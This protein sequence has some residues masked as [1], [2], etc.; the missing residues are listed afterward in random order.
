MGHVHLRVADLGDAVA[1]YRDLLGFGL[2]AELFGSA[3]FF[4]AGGYHHHVGANTWQSLGA[5]PPPPGAAALRR[6]TI[7]LPDGS[8]LDRLAERVARAGLA[9]EGHDGGVLVRDPSGTAVV[10]AA[11]G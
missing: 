3:A 9:P 6:V 11:A 8:E 4:G 1:F 7:V 10:L 5:S 2:M